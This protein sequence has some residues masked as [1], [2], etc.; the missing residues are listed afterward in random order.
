[1]DDALATTVADPQKFARLAEKLAQ[2]DDASKAA[3]HTRLQQDAAAIRRYRNRTALTPIVVG[4]GR[5]DALGLIHNQVQSNTMAIPENWRAA[6]APVKPSFC[7][8]VPQSAWAQWSGVLKDPILRNLGEVMGVFAQI[9]LT[10]NAPEAGL[11]DSTVDLKGQIASEDLL[12]RLAPP[13]WPEE[14]LGKIDQTRQ[15]RVNSSSRRIALRATPPGRT[16]GASRRS[17]AS[18]S[19]RMPSSQSTSSEP[20]R[21]NSEVRNSRR[22]PTVMAGPL[23][24]ISSHHIRGPRSFRPPLSL[25]RRRRGFSTDCLPSSMSA[26]SE[27]IAAHGYR[28]FYPEALEPVPALF[29]YKANPAEGMWASP[30]YLHNG[31]VPNL[32]ELLSPASGAFQDVLHRP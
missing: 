31:S 16:V 22:K 26:R 9:D 32:Y 19:S 3:L 13:K 5:M 7:W 23:S 6:L 30:P 14:I 15:P 12:R 29:A 8:N 27:L 2:N 1:M 24:N 21:R 18:D 25:R 20:T 17:W 10:S 4:P 28:A 11:F